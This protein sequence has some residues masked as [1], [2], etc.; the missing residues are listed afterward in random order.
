MERG[1]RRDKNTKILYQKSP[2]WRLIKL[3]MNPI[4]CVAG[5]LPWAV[6]SGPFAGTVC[7]LTE[8]GDGVVAK[9]AGT[10][11]MEIYPAFVAASRRSPELVVDIGSAEGFYVAGLAR[12]CPDAKVVAYEAKTLWQERIRSVVLAN[13]V[14]DRCEVRGFCD[15]TEFHRV[16]GTARGKRVFVLMDIEGGEFDLIDKEVLSLLSNTELLV[17]LHERESRV[18]GEALIRLLES[19]HKVNVI[20][21]NETRAPRDVKSLGW[22]I[23]AT[24]LPPVR[25]RLDEGRGYRMRW[26]HA[27]PK[28]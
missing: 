14:A 15:K 4:K 10:Y 27:A 18:N 3:R 6:S 13:G 20:W 8:G 25:Q 28:S 11:E 26:L 23:A 2:F 22:R 19:S 17:E 16:L 1:A 21:S 7:R 5:K 9:L 12:V 24:L